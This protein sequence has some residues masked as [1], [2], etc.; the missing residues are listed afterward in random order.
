MAMTIQNSLSGAL[1]GGWDIKILATDI[2]TNVL[3]TAK[4][5]IYRDDEISSI[6]SKLR[7]SYFSPEQYHGKTVYR[8]KSNI[9]DLIYFRHLNLLEDPWPLKPSTLFDIIFCRNVVIYFDQH[10]QKRL[11]A[12][13]CEKMSPGGYLFI[14]HSESLY[15]ISDDFV[16]LKNT[17]YRKPF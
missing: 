11:F 3:Q 8:A 10:T 1:G 7:E 2:D 4:D 5:G 15:R 14:G 12:R 9:R 6:P 17:I 16:S 13:F